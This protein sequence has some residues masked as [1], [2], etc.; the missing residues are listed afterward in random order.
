MT[1]CIRCGNPLRRGRTFCSRSCAKRQYFE[2]NPS[3]KRTYRLLF[4]P[5]HPLARECGLVLEHRL[6]L[7][8]AGVPI[9][10]GHQVHHVNGDRLDNRLENL[11]VLPESDHHRLHVQQAGVITNQFGTFPL[12]PTDPVENREHM[13]ELSRQSRRRRQA[14]R[15]QQRR[16]EQA[17]AAACPEFVMAHAPRRGPSR[18][19]CGALRTLHSAAVS[20]A[21]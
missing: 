12:R 15:D 20:H 2:D 3:P 18:C 14:R 7:Y 5:G 1:A 16:A 21:A 13:Q 17:I 8:E 6:V 19:I 10:D 11:Q 4:R 9:P